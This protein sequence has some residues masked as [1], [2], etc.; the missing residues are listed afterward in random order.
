MIL[1]ANLIYFSLKTKSSLLS[2]TAPGLCCLC[3]CLVVVLTLLTGDVR[4]VWERK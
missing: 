4:G 3:L 1:E 2:L